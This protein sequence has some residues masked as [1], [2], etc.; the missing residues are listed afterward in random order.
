MAI[1]LVFFVPSIFLGGL[2]L[3]I[4]TT[5]A[6]S[7]AASAVVPATHFIVIARGVFLK[8][9]GVMALRA[10]ALV[11]LGIGGATVALSLAM[12]RK[13]IE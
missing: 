1:I 12:F 4:D 7:R 10:P 13:R 9:L 5:S 11:L 2:I 6:V 8:G 3:P